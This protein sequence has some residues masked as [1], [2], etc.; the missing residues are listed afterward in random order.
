MF[1]GF[2]QNCEK[3]IFVAAFEV[4]KINP[5]NP[6]FYFNVELV[7]QI[8]ISFFTDKFITEDTMVT[9]SYFIHKDCL[10]TQCERFNLKGEGQ[11]SLIKERSTKT[12]DMHCVL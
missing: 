10:Q 1:Q 11:G 3:M 5:T 8:K 6:F 7:G 9:V 4:S 2:R 12:V